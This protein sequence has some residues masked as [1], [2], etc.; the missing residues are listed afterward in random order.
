MAHLPSS[1]AL[2]A[3]L[4]QRPRLTAGRRHP[5]DTNPAP[6]LPATTLMPLRGVFLLKQ[7][8]LL[9]RTAPG[10]RT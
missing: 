2:S 9:A 7:A 10:P 5:T 3:L 6:A 4:K 1:L 8:G